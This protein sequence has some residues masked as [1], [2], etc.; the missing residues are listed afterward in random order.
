MRQLHAPAI[1]ILIAGATA[2]GGSNAGFPAVGNAVR[3]ATIG[4]E[5]RANPIQ[6]VIVIVQRHRGF[7]NLFAAFPGADAPMDGRLHTGKI[8]ALKPMRLEQAPRSS[9][10]NYAFRVPYD[11][12]KMDRFDEVYTSQPLF[13][14]HY[15]VHSEIGPYWAFAKR[16]VLADHMFSTSHANSDFVANLYLVAARSKVGRDEFIADHPSAEPWGCDAPAGT[17]TPVYTKHGVDQGGPFPCFSFASLPN[18][19]DAAN[20]SWR[21]YTP[22][23]PV[24]TSIFD[25]IKYVRYGKDWTRDISSPQTNVLRDISAGKLPQVAWVI[26]K[27]ADSDDPSSRGNTG[28][29]WVKSVVDAV[30]KTSY[31]RNTAI[32]VVWDN[33]DY[34][35][36]DVPP[37]QL[38][39]V[40]LGYRVPMLVISSYAKL[41]YVSHTQYEFGSILKFIEERFH[42]GSLGQTDARANSISDCFDFANPSLQ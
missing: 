16:F 37:P 12:G 27:A 35:Y 40:G 29:A 21:Y 32:I 20:V 33:S 11:G 4:V 6:H 14:Y 7:D 36:D 10:S 24:Y 30:Q 17:T 28:P 2:C 15:I 25:A 38:D 42:L 26:P 22:K 13:P 31:W 3:R 8:I 39:P 5:G 18:L 1:L 9:A 34:F 41:G 23:P 19:L